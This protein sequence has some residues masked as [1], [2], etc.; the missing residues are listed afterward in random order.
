[1]NSTGTLIA[2]ASNDRVRLWHLSNERTV[3][4]FKHSQPVQ[5]ITF[6]LDGERILI[7]GFGNEMWEWA[8]PRDILEE[9]AKNKVDSL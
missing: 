9:L 2:S 5:C 3:T 4:I 7:V 6:S 8:V 1:V